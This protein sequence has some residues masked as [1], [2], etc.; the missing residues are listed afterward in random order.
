MNNL[1]KTEIKRLQNWAVFG[2]IILN[3]IAFVFVSDKIYF[4]LDMTQGKKYSISKPTVELLKKLDNEMIIEYYYNDKFKAH[5]EMAPVVQYVEDILNEYERASKKHLNVLVKELSYDNPNDAEKI[6]DLEGV[7]INPVP[8]QERQKAEE[9]TS[10]GFSGIIIKYK[11]ENKVIPVIFNDIAF[12]YTLDAEINKLIE[13]ESNKIGLVFALNDKDYNQEYQY[14]NYLLSNEF[15]NPVMIESGKPIPN[16]V[17]ALVIIGG[18]NISDYDTYQIDQFLLNNGKAFIALGGVNVILTQGMPFGIP[19]DSKLIDLLSSYGIKINTDIVGDNDSYTPYMEKI[20]NMFL[21]EH[22]YPIWPKINSNNFSKKHAAVDGMTSLNLFWPSSITVDEKIKKQTDVLFHTTENA[23]SLKEQYQLTLDA[24]MY[25]MQKAE[26]ALDIG[27][28]FEGKINSYFSDKVLPSGEG[29]DETTQNNKLESGNAK[30]VV[31]ANDY[32]LNDNFLSQDQ[33]GRF[34]LLNS[35][36]WLTKDNS[37]IQ[38]RNKGKF[39]RPLYKAG[40]EIQLANRKSFIIIFS[41][42]VTPIIFIILA[43]LAF[44]FRHIKNESF[45]RKIEEKK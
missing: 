20:Q 29:I 44:V 19:S 6:A 24:Y 40:N 16:E 30:I 7:G 18:N 2:L 45:K 8:L 10:L 3:L 17:S 35:L 4:R 37:L 32:F 13:K 1:D 34:F 31:V 9:R 15:G 25:P 28:A 43:C 33:E 23:F 36:D 21:K 39:N 38:I 14:V 41:T 27:C 12:E 42:V 22:R 5:T 11:G 26:G